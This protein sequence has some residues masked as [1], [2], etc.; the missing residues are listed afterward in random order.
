MQEREPAVTPPVK[1]A[2]GRNGLLFVRFFCKKAA[3]EIQYID[4]NNQ[5]KRCEN[6]KINVDL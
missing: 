3:T 6:A 5:N 2:P 4:R 1:A